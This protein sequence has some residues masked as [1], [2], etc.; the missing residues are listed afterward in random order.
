M[1]TSVHPALASASLTGLVLIVC[2]MQVGSLGLPA[3]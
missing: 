3:P 2:M 1:P